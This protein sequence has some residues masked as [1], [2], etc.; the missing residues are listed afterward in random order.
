MTRPKRL[1]FSFTAPPLC[2]QQAVEQSI[3]RTSIDISMVPLDES[4]SISLARLVRSGAI[5]E[6]RIDESAAR[7]MQ[8]PRRVRQNGVA[9]AAVAVAVAV[10][11]A[12]A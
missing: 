12:A 2:S 6:A 9:A 10:L 1:S 8:V 3:N 7:I 4:F 5:S 11:V